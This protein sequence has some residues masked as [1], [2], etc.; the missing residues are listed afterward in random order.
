MRQRDD[1]HEPLER[2]ELIPAGL[3]RELKDRDIQIFLSD[4]CFSATHKNLRKGD[5]TCDLKC[6]IRH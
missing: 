6:D 3:S 4:L 2:A 1:S 5:T